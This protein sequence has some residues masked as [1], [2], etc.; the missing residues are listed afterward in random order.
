MRAPAQL[1]LFGVPTLF[2]AG[3][4]HALPMERRSQLLVWL[5]LH[6][7]WAPRS[8]AAALLW[9]GV[10]DRLALA[11]LRKTL[12]RLATLPWGACVRG[13]GGA[14]R[15]EGQTD[16]AGF[17]AALRDHRHA[18]ALALASGPLLQG[19]DDPANEAWTAWLGFERDSRRAAWRGAALAALAAG[20]PPPAAVALAAQLLDSDPHDDAALREQVR[21]LVASHQ[22]DAALHAIDRFA[23]RLHDEL[24]VAPD[25]ALRTL[26][27]SLESGAPH[28]PAAP[29]PPPALVEEGFIGRGAELR[30]IASLLEQDDCRVLCLLGPGGVGKTRLARRA[31]RELAPGHADGALFVSLEGVAGADGFAVALT[32]ALELQG[33]AR[34][35]A[36]P[37]AAAIAA[38]QTRRLLL[39]LDNFED[40]AEEAALLQPLVEGCPRLKLLLTSRVMPQGIDA[41]R[42]VLEGLPYPDAE[43]LDRLEAF[44]AVRLFV[45]HAR[46]VE[47]AFS[48]AAEPAA[49]VEICR[50]VDGLP[51]ALELAAAWVRLMPC[52]S[53]AAELRAGG[54]LLGGA[55]DGT[56]P[57]PRHASLEQ[58][59]EQSWQ[60]LGAREQV[61]LAALA[62]FRGSFDADAARAV[63]GR[64][65][66]AL[67]VLAALLDKSLL[68]KEGARLKL[69]PLVQQLASRRLQA[70]AGDAAQ[71][72]RSAHAGWYLRR[73]ERERRALEAGDRD[74]LARLDPDVDN[75][76]AAWQWAATVGPSVLAGAPTQR[77]LAESAWALMAHFELRGLRH[78]ALRLGLWALATPAAQQ[79]AALR[80]VLLAGC[81][82]TAHRL[83]RWE[84]ATGWAEQALALAPGRAGRVVRRHALSTLAGC[85]SALGRSEAARARY[86]QAL[87]L[88]AD[89]GE[90]RN[91]ATLH[92]NLALVEKR[93]GRYEPALRLTH[94]AL[95][96]H[97]RLQRP[98]DEARCL[99]NLGD[100]H[101]QTHDLDAARSVLEQALALCER[102]G[103]HGVLGLVLANLAYEA[104]ARSDLP[105]AAGWVR[106]ALPV[107]QA[108]GD[109][110]NTAATRQQLA[111]IERRRGD[112]AAARRE[113]ALAMRE[114]QHLGHALLSLYGL[115]LLAELLEGDGAHTEAQAVRGFVA[116]H[117]AATPPLRSE[118]A[119]RLGAAGRRPPWPAGLGLTALVQRVADEADTGYAGLRVLLNGPA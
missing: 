92:E 2:R 107:L 75:A 17:D 72:A 83:G 3:T 89:D 87:K 23:Q 100:L 95:A 4:G 64:T 114:A 93:L 96:T 71:A 1:R 47:P 67:P 85:D 73:L 82:F 56:P 36:T 6:G 48:A 14:L 104:E 20:M 80:A 88:A 31:L 43:D 9:P 38:L 29:P 30:R 16:L 33:S 13:E 49:L 94:E 8:Q 65:Q 54:E 15:F 27:A 106:R 91:A 113:L 28:T 84:Q 52:S 111:S 97:R 18:D 10:E 119:Q 11:N 99:N 62:V 108:S 22:R 44:D 40:L 109:A 117:E 63:A 35:Q 45:R 102:H 26:R 112:T 78:E 21:A 74:A 77:L 98:A 53:I 116:D 24:G 25:A 79:H 42:F 12:H 7:G 81:A 68:H 5:A 57:P 69:H 90:L 58:V 115:L 51:L 86:E 41:W 19:F 59:F 66:P 101:L 76:R 70:A 34:G 32:Q 118:L 103:L 50:L 39:V 105:A 60:R 110:V 37:L 55:P 61:A 46:R